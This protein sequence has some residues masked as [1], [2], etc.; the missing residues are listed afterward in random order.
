MSTEEI[1]LFLQEMELFQ[2]VPDEQMKWF[3]E[4]SEVNY[5]EKGEELFTPGKSADHIY[6]I[7]SGHFRLCFERNGKLQEIGE[8]FPKEIT[9]VLPYSR[10]KTTSG[11]GEALESSSVLGFHRNLFHDMI[12]NHHELTAVFVQRMTDRIRNFTTFQQQNEKLASLGKLSAGLAHELNN[13]ASAVVRSSE[14]LKKH[15]NNTP[16]KFKEVLAI[17]VT[18]EQVD[19]VNEVLFSRISDFSNVRLS[20]MEKTELEDDLTD[21]MDEKGMDDSL[22]MA[23]VFAEYNFRIEDFEKVNEH[24]PDASLA[25]VFGWM[26]SNIV[27]EKMVGEIADASK[28]IS[29]L[30]GSVK[31]Y[32]HMDRSQD[33]QPTD[34]HEGLRSTVTMLGHKIRQNKIVL[35]EDFGLI[36]KIQA[37]PGEVNQVFTNLID[38]AI[39]AM[40]DGGGKLKI[41]TIQVGEFVEVRINDSGTGITDEAIKKV[42]DPFYTTKEIGKGTGMGLDLVLKIMKQRHHGSVKVVSE[43]GNTTFTLCFPIKG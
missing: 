26:A 10:M 2:E 21:W 13:P 40:E 34:L 3:A 19:A 1:I 37:F 17:D 43:P 31:N 42:F 30:V 23:E 14:A 35:E 8:L 12:C 39:D 4:N 15:L 5:F 29:E 24:V 7:M 28:R 16:E 9:G 25:A 33:K 22:E 32:T 38:N 41:T 27:T 11:I 18:P 6:I 36:P 20:L